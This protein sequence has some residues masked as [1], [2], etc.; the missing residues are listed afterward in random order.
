LE[1]PQRCD[2]VGAAKLLEFP[3]LTQPP[4]PVNGGFFLRDHRPDIRVPELPLAACTRQRAPGHMWFAPGRGHVDVEDLP[5]G[6][7]SLGAFTVR[8]WDSRVSRERG[9]LGL[10]WVQGQLYP[11]LG[12]G[13]AV[14][15]WWLLRL[16]PL[17]KGGREV[18]RRGRCRAAI[19][20]CFL[21]RP[22]STPAAKVDSSPR[23]TAA[24]S[25]M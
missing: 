5:Q 10:W 8:A 15:D 21:P 25:S 7:S 4:Q 13:F 22:A 2:T 11:N 12:L 24:K 20:R 17:G 14:T 3:P 6:G 19:T 23:S 1:V 16:L 9:A 18:D